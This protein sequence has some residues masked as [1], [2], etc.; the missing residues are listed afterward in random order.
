MKRYL[1]LLLIVM[2][3]G[4]VRAEEPGVA[5]VWS[6]GTAYLIPQGSW[7]TG[8]IQAFRYGL[9]ETIE[10]HTHALILPLMPNVGIKWKLAEVNGWH[11]AAQHEL[12]YPSP[13]LNTLSMKGIGGFIAPDFSF[14]NLVSVGNSVLASRYM[15]ESSLLSANLGIYFTI[16][17]KTPDPQS[18]IDLPILYPRMAHWYK[19]ASLR[20]GALFRTQVVGKL[21]AEEILKGYYITRESDNLFFEEGINLCWGLGRSLRIKAGYTLS[22]GTYPFGNQ[23][24][25]SPSVDLVFGSAMFIK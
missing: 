9:N 10:L 4:V 16:R 18:T 13:L 2:A 20:A 8:L 14:G 21:F 19:G 23:W 24:Q 12:A 6:E 11:V 15:G 5:R 1:S 25:L 17:D 3:V 7:E 22:Y